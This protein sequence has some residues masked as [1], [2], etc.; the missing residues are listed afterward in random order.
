MHHQYPSF[1]I[2]PSGVPF[3]VWWNIFYRKWSQLFWAGQRRGLVY[4]SIQFFC[5][6]IHGYFYIYLVLW[7]YTHFLN[8]RK[9]Q[10]R[11][12]LMHHCLYCH[13]DFFKPLLNCTFVALLSYFK[14][15][16]H[17]YDIKF[18]EL[19]SMYVPI[20]PKF[21]VLDQFEK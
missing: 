11:C 16:S 17:P 3:I 9:T 13:F 18:G 1:I 15:I 14:K 5:L 10:L 6:L 12:C 21:K 4:D 7:C 2:S 8:S 19:F 20:G